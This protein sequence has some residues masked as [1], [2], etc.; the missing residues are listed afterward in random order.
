MGGL[1][2]GGLIGNAAAALN[3]SDYRNYLQELGVP[4]IIN[5]RGHNTIMTG[6][7]M[8]PEVMAA[9]NS[10]ANDFVNLEVLQDKAG[11]RI[12][13]ML[14]CE[15]AMVTSGAASA[16]TLGTAAC[17]TGTDTEKIVQL[18]DLPGPQKEVIVQKSHRFGYDHAVRN[19]GIKFVEVE[20][21][22]E[23]ER[24]VN[25]NT[26][27][28]FYFN[29]G[30]DSGRIKHEEFIELAQ[31]HGLPTLIDCAAELPP[32]DNLWRF[33]GMGFDLVAFSGG[34]E[35]RGPQ[36]AGLLLGRKDLIEAAR[37]QSNP[38]GNTIGRGMK[39]NKE[40]IVG[41]TIAVETYLEMDHQHV[42]DERM[43][44]VKYVGDHVG[45]LRGV[46]QEIQMKEKGYTGQV[47]V[48]VLRVSWDPNTIRRSSSDILD[49]MISG[50]PA[51]IIGGGNN[52]VSV[53]L[54]ME[55]NG[56][57]RIVAR[58]LHEELSKGYT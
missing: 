44:R 14:R 47:N 40:E 41:M 8:M 23:L 24:A 55:R 22:R 46:E 15:G 49:S 43:A 3:Q 30:T 45:S 12:A 2:G 42:L 29:R 21:R 54:R 6:S 20:T 27:M 26:V 4:V 17:L 10:T 52:S 33:T 56:T 48:P 39:V 25:E 58:R 34:K 53:N 38:K 11:E 16:L 51:I 13:S 1:F 19:T 57:E 32:V 31:K 28:M 18:P 36:S 7:L 9:I 5:A 37:E 35:I 50:H